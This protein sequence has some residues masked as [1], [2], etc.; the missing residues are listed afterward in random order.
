MAWTP[1][2]HLWLGHRLDTY[3]PRYDGP[4]VCCICCTRARRPG[5]GPDSGPGPGPCLAVGCWLLA[6][7]FELLAVSWVD[8]SGSFGALGPTHHTLPFEIRSSAGCAERGVQSGKCGA[9]GF[10]SSAGCAERQVHGM[11]CTAQART[12][13]RRH[14]GTYAGT[15]VTC[16][17]L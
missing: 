7:G 11:R 17:H 1:L 13:A 6:A 16:V 8:V 15:H 4:L 10:R 5:P 9:L 12:Q 3:R 2:G 14:A